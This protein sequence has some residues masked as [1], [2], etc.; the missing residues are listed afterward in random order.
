MVAYPLRKHGGRLAEPIEAQV[1]RLISAG[2][3]IEARVVEL[4]TSEEGWRVERALFRAMIDQVPDYLFVKGTDSRFI[5]VN[6]AVAAD[7]GLTPAD[8]MGKIDFELHPPERARKFFA[9]EQ[10]VISTGEPMLDIEEFVL[11]VSGGKKWLSTSKVPL[12]N[13]QNEIIGIV[14]IARDITERKRAED[15]IHFM[16]HHDALTG[17]PNRILLMDRLTQALLQA[18]RN[19]WRVTVIFIDLDHFKLI[20][21]SLGHSA[22]DTLLRIVAERMTGCVRATDTVV[23]LGGDEFIILLIDQAAG[24]SSTL[25]ILDKIRAAIAEPIL[26]GGHLLHVTC[27]IGLATSPQDGT[28]AETLLMNAD[29]A[30][31][32]AKEKGRDNFQL[33]TAEMNDA[34]DERRGLQESLRTGLQR[35]E[36]ALVYQPQ[37]DLQSGRVFAVEA[38]VR[39]N[40]PKLGVVTPEKFI[41]IAE[42]S[43]LIVQLGD[44]VLREACR[45]NK[46][47][48][49]AGLVPIT[50]SVNVS[51][52]QFREKGWVKRVTNALRE[53][54]LEAKYLELEL[55]ESLLMQDVTQAI[56]TMRELQTIGVRFAIDD[57]GTGYSSLS[58]LKSFPVA[59]LKIDRSFVRNLPHDASDRSIATAVISL[60]QKLNMKVIAEGVESE[61]QASFLRD[62]NCDEIQGFLF[63]KPIESDAVAAMLGSQYKSCLDSAWA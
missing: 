21:D 61:D 1:D 9:D 62:N 3:R 47:W 2:E 16:A 4:L 55:T 29:V 5:V 44:W 41:P 56:A 22:G 8:L 15:Q 7:L 10:R 54:G 31:Y 40:H 33:H 14:G 63:S 48:Q 26:M 39:W 43:G 23:R 51:A 6:R 12:R 18:Q 50:I 37:V 24:A 52:R 59:R 45:Q 11:D 20:N 19:G 38:L 53:S 30:M 27:S 57:F 35:N 42:E 13:E 17:L 34:A 36:F 25:A 32:R 58:A 28:D 60:G 49:D 46:A